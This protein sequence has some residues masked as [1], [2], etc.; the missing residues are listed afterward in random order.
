MQHL[1]IYIYTL[2]IKREHT[3]SFELY[4]S[5]LYNTKCV[6]SVELQ[7]RIIIFN[8]LVPPKKIITIIK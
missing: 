7:S 3:L 6:E 8:G 2:T 1:Y 5:C 4:I